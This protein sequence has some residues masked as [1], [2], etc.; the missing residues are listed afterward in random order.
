MRAQKPRSARGREIALLAQAV[1]AIS[2]IAKPVR[3][4]NA[5]SAGLDWWFAKH[6]AAKARVIPAA[7]KNQR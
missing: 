2:M 5:V 4:E 7:A 1:A 6:T 3:S